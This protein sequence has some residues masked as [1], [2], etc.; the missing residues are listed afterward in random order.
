[1]SVQLVDVLNQVSTPVEFLRTPND[2]TLAAFNAVGVADGTELFFS[3]RNT[4]GDGGGGVFYY[5][6]TMSLAAD[7]VFIFEPVA[8]G[9]RL[10]R[11]G[12][13][14]SGF[15]GDVN[16]AW[17][18]VTPRVS[19]DPSEDCT[20][21]INRTIL[22]VFKLH[23]PTLLNS[24]NRSKRVYFPQGFDY[25]ILGTCL[26]PPGIHVD[27]NGGRLVGADPD[28]GTQPFSTSRQ[29]MWKTA[30]W[31]GTA[32][33]PN[34][35][36][37]DDR[38][39]RVLNARLYG[40]AFLNCNCPIDFTNFQEFCAL[41]D[42]YFDNTSAPVRL[43]GSYYARIGK[44]Q[45]LLARNSCLSAGQP[46]LLLH[47]LSAHELYIDISAPSASV[48]LKV[49]ATQ[50]YNV[51]VRGSCEEG[52]ANGS[53]GILNADAYCQAW[54]VSMYYE[55]VRSG[56]VTQGTG[57]FN[58]T[59][60]S[61]Q[62]FNG[63]EYAVRGVAGSFRGGTFDA[64]ACP[65][66][67]GDIRNLVDYSAFNNDVEVLIPSK[68]AST[69]TGPVAFPTN[70]ILKDQ[71]RPVATSVWRENTDP[72][73]TLAIALPGAAR[74]DQLNP[75][76]FEGGHVKAV[77]NQPPFVTITR[78]VDTMTVATSIT[79]D[80]CNALVFHFFGAT[81]AI[82]YTLI[83]RVHGSEVFWDKRDPL[84]VVAT[85]S[86]VGGYVRIVFTNLTATIPVINVSGYVR[87]L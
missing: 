40:G 81:D 33:V 65:D 59:V 46:A 30:R 62:Q 4:S 47:G 42:L 14:T 84:A 82:S 27:V 68:G 56:I 39:Y 41:D 31:N 45:K 77:A 38:T 61:P 71:A 18:G 60:F 79:Y 43:K 87:H 24:G 9:G 54:S 35:D 3:G 11:Q 74:V 17:G 72:T 69:L 5:S 12:W 64:R 15:Y 20:A 49:T 13:T 76:A 58:G 50:S 57:T 70:F 25:T 67:G 8:G 63:C 55:G 29:S 86:N 10:V 85:V 1:M 32:L 83:G 19:G 78:A 52:H 73:T 53:I 44:R 2:G 66:N 51:T 80:P 21:A 28:A 34:E 7:N 23:N 75:F 48:T 6:S 36:A 26:L 22:A 16:L 37:P